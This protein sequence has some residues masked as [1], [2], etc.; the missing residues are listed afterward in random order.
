MMVAQT[1][2]ATA[3]HETHGTGYGLET[4]QPRQGLRPVRGTEILQ[5]PGC[6]KCDLYQDV[7]DLEVIILIEQWESQA[8]LDRRLGSEEYRAVLAAI[9]LAREQPE[10]HFDTVIRRG[11][12]EVVVTARA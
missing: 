11:G 1:T 9:E 7:E 10:I 5:Q 4:A 8:D 12:L 3:A 6:D 2:P